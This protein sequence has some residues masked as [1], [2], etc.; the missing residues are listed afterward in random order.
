MAIKNTTELRVHLLN[1]MEELAKGNVDVTKVNATVA[2]AKQVN[3]TLSLELAAARLMSG[4]GMS[5][6]SISS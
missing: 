2:L 4:N 6:L 5:P 3:I 1:Q